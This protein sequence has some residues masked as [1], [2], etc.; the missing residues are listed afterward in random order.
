M[1]KLYLVAT[2]ALISLFANAQ[3][4]LILSTGAGSNLQNYT[5]KVC[6]V[7]ANRVV[8]TGWN[9]I[10]L[11]FSLTES[12]LNEAFGDD[13]R[14]E[15]LVGVE[16]AG[17]ALV[18]NFQDCKSQGLQANV[19]YI[20]HFTGATASKRIVKQTLV[21]EGI[22]SLSFTVDGTVVTMRG[23]DKQTD[24]KGLYGILAKDNA[25]AQF[26]SVDDIANGFHATRC[27]ISISNDNTAILKTNHIAAGEVTSIHAVAKVGEKVDVYNV[28]G[29]KV[30]DNTNGL[31]PG[32]YI[33]K[34]RKVLVK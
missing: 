16:N 8:F 1:K 20:L 21:E 18:L 24:S 5:G 12:E 34:G 13:C 15:K 27:C 30:A 25:E 3:Q 11:P 10:S 14:L 6:D 17:G 4:K 2:M 32:I 33:V 7:T 22:S 19:P 26:V 23:L 29:I 31:Q 28:S 9:T